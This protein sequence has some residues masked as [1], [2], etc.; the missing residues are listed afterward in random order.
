MPQSL[1]TIPQRARS[2]A[3]SEPFDGKSTG[4]TEQIPVDPVTGQPET[5]AALAM[6]V[7]RLDTIIALLELRR[8][9][10]YS[11]GQSVSVPDTTPV[12]V[13]YDPALFSLVIT[14]DGPGIV[15]YRLP[16]RGSA[17]WLNLNAAEQATFSFTEGVIS[18][19]A[20]RVQGA[21]TV[22][23]LLGSN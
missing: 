21:A 16:D 14:N 7:A 5:G 12:Q 19:V 2:Y 4:G 23:R 9:R 3:Y 17:N 8:N 20:F 6:M 22:V 18:S 10:G 11:F 1:R 15:Q 13:T